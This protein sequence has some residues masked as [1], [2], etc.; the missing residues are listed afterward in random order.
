VRADP[1]A[2]STVERPAP[3][4]ARMELAA[5]AVASASST[6]RS[7]VDAG[8]NLVSYRAGNA[9]DGRRS[10]AW[11]TP[12]DGTG[13]T[14]TLT[15]DH[16]VRVA[17]VGLIPGYDKHDPY[18]GADRFLQ[19]RRVAAARVTFSD[20]S[21]WDLTIADSRRLQRFPIAGVTDSVTIE[22]LATVPGQPGFDDT[23][24][25]EVSVL[26]RDA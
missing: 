8:G 15:W 1:P 11:R 19:N 25:S 22:V 14:L 21:A 18:D 5:S 10:T 13:E 2:S 3:P 26:G 4:P 23:V 9:I 17:S 20:G 24:I 7:S 12:G 16:P 6:A